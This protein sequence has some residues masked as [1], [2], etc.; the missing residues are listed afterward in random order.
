MIPPIVV[1]ILGKDKLS[2]KLGALNKRLTKFG[3]RAS[4]IGKDMTMK[5]TLPIA[6]AG[7]SFLKM[8]GNFQEGMNML[9]ASTQ[10][11]DG[12]F[13]AMRK[14]ALDL[15]AST[16]YTATQATEG[17]QKL[18]DSGFEVNEILQAIGPS[19]NLAAAGGMELGVT[20][21]FLSDAMNQ[22]GLDASQAT[23]VSNT[24]AK[25]SKAGATTLDKMVES[26]S[27]FGPILHQAG[28]SIWETSKAVAILGS[29]GR[30]S[31]LAG[32]DLRAVIAS[33][34]KP[35]AE[36]RQAL[37]NLGIKKSDV[38][39]KNGQEIKSLQILFDQLKKVGATTQD[40]AT[41]FRRTGMA[42]AGALVQA[43]DGGWDAAEA[44]MQRKMITAE[45]LAA[46]RMKGFNGAMKK[47]QAAFEAMAIAVA[48]S[49]LLEFATKVVLK[50]T[51]IF[52]WISKSHPGWLKWGTILLGFLAI[53][54]PV[55]FILGK[56]VLVGSLLIPV[57]NGLIFIVT[58]LVSIFGWWL[59]PIG[60]VIAALH[61]LIKNWDDVKKALEIGWDGLLGG[62]KDT[63]DWIMKIIGA[64]KNLSFKKAFKIFGGGVSGEGIGTNSNWNAPGYGYAGMGYSYQQPQPT[65]S[66]V[67]VEFKNAPKGTAVE[68]DDE[69]VDTT[70]DT[71]YTTGD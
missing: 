36:A 7:G 1:D 24:L 64:L 67:E 35:S 43:I 40:L 21:D 22:F 61:L 19:L 17:M 28:I 33:I 13:K 54:G 70:M 38:F 12:Q 29:A 65:T 16:I 26:F 44:K 66:K 18:S 63:Y 58:G 25:A 8:A 68:S 69:N 50:L 3:K 23:Y 45:N 4:K 10:A 51:D 39:K 32:T 30:K 14:T 34:I 27:Q 57:L 11:T 37:I 52:T 5:M 9:Q 6:V 20:A 49:G 41:I 55:I 48:D 53:L 60:L 59:I 47:M 56:L 71:G 62:F 31:S 42:G 46:A 2:T 15:G